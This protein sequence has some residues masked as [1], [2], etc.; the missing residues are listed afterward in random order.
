MGGFMKMKPFAAAI[1]AVASLALLVP[2]DSVATH[3]DT[4]EG[5]VI[6]EW[7]QILQDTIGPTPPFL[8]VR[9]FAMMHV[10]MF[11]SIN[12]IEGAYTRYHTKVW[13]SHGAS[14]D[15]AAA[16]AAHDVLVALLPAST[17]TYDAALAQTL[18]TIDE[19]RARQGVR[20]GKAVAQR[21][22]A[23]RENDGWQIA[24]PPYVQPL[25]PGL[26]QPTPPGFLP[27][28]FTQVTNVE[29]FALLT[30]TQYLP[31]RPPTLTS[32]QYAEEFNE[33]KELGSATSTVRTEDQTLLARLFAGVGYQTTAFAIWNNV[34]RDVARQRDYCLIDTA[35]LF[36]QL[37][38]S[39]NDGLQTSQSSKF[40]YG[41][42]RPVT[43]IQRAEE[44]LNPL[45]LP[46]ATWMPLLVT[47][48]YPSYAGN[49]SCIGASAARALALN[50]GTNDIPVT[51]RWV[52]LMGNADV[53]LHYA[54][55]WELA[56]A[57]ALSRVYGG[58]HFTFESVGSQESCPKVADYVFENYMKPK[59]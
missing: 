21:I 48:P 24:P 16:Q 30:N 39:I 8:T 52:G 3:K 51:A 17:S 44:D 33:V 5:R 4:H 56:E 54:S 55:F 19:G 37:N 49:M 2:D 13:A 11:D 46:D 23:W 47:P 36:A 31:A 27:A 58:I 22:I 34:A 41:L 10:A 6:I 15:A 57:A 20:V 14:S 12:S 35:R 40:V 53:S 59:K 50:F 38:V 32:E 1:L 18:A 28:T 9:A 43:A 7:N 42:W 29:P 26:W 25:L 45:T